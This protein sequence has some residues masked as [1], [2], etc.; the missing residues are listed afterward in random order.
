MCSVAP[1]A[2]RWSLGWAPPGSLPRMLTVRSLGKRFG[3]RIA[4]SGVS[5]ELDVGE[6][7]A[8]IGPNGAGKTTLLSIL[9]GVLEPTEGQVVGA[10]HAPPRGSAHAPTQD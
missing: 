9:A 3:S 8:I 5:F 6:L 1:A 2:R 4:L 7:V 10:V